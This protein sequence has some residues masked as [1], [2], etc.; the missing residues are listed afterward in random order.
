MMKQ[1]ELAC[2]GG[3]HADY[4]CSEQD[5]LI[6]VEIHA[7][8]EEAAPMSVTLSWQEDHVRSHVAYS[9]IEYLS[10]QI[11]PEWVG[12]RRSTGTSGA[13]FHCVIDYNDQ[14]RLSIACSDALN[15]VTV[16][17]NLREETARLECKVTMTTDYPISDY[18]ATVRIDKRDIPFYEAA[19]DTVRWWASLPGYTPAV[20]PDAAKLPYYSTW[21]SFHQNTDAKEILQELSHAAALGCTAVIVDDGWQC[22]NSLRGYD[23]CGDWEPFSGKIPDMKAFVDGAHALGMKFLLWYS[24]PFIG[25]LAKRRSEFRG[26]ML[27]DSQGVLDP[28]YPEN[29]AFLKNTLVKAV[30]DWGLDGF[31]LDFIDTFPCQFGDT[32]TSSTAPGKDFV[33]VHQAV[34]VMAKDIL[35][36]L[37]KL[38]PDILIEFRQSYI[39]PLMRTYGNIF[40]AS[41]CPNDSHMNRMST[42]ALRILSGETAVHSDMIMWNQNETAEE[43]AFQFTNILF[44][45]PQISVRY[46]RLPESHRQMLRFYT[47]FWTKHRHTL[48]EGRMYYQD[49]HANYTYVS[50]D[51]KRCT[52]GALYALT[53][54]PIRENKA[55]IVVVNARLDTEVILNVKTDLGVKQLEI[56][57][58]MGHVTE[59]TEITL[60]PGLY[61][62][63]VPVN[64]MLVLTDVRSL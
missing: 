26:K 46:E 62:V 5:G 55:E 7:R 59:K 4:T 45:V 40:R 54:V 42:L 63:R 8:A 33:S 1:F 52:V 15:P 36:S 22:D 12:G 51:D 31:K 50:A 25:K 21:Y 11:F 41:D 6:F 53:P 44:S 29:R 56:S 16:F 20:V 37:R 17:C 48:L 13:P 57:D 35:T 27:S 60:S 34:D 39:G 2:E 10:K 58:C 14:N 19:A 38:N 9:P 61:T 43:A 64:G 47:D 32:D 30:R 49:Y 23:Y 28:R 18:Q 3:F 24:V